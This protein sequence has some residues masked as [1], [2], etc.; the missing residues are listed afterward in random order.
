MKDL[1]MPAGLVPSQPLLVVEGL[2]LTTFGCCLIAQGVCGLVGVFGCAA[3]LMG[4]FL[5]GL[6]ARSIKRMEGIVEAE[7]DLIS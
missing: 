5:M 1:E 3:A 6:I 7:H 4:R 2:N